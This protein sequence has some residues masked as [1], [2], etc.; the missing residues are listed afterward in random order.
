M[1]KLNLLTYIFISL[2]ILSCK[3]IDQ[4]TQ[5]LNEE[6]I[7]T[8][9]T[10]Y[11]NQSVDGTNVAR[12]VII[13]TP[14]IIDQSKDYPLVFAFHGRGG[15]NKIWVNK[16]KNF[17]DSGE[18]IGVYPQGYLDSWNLGTEP[19]KADDIEFISMIIN[20]LKQYNNIDM[21]K[22]YAIGISNGSGMVNKLGI[23]TSHFKAIAPIVS[24]LM[25]SMPILNNTKPI[26]VFQFNG[27]LDST[28]PINGGSRFGHVFLDALKSAEL[29]AT[30]FECSFPAEIQSNGNNTLY[31]FSDC[32]DGKEIRY[33]RIKNG[34]HNLEPSLP[35]MFLEI[36]NF[37]KKF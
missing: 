2:L 18:F 30:N 36:W 17:T 11:I 4:D 10:V 7:L 8:T 9:K 22:L 29:W 5:D 19:S 23:E 3:K 31:I 26:S 27:A 14:S 16:L 6:N 21:N 24:Q 12:S 35:T 1:N 34:Q 32:N 15:K 37:F 20:R 33:Y 28:I 25:E 13:Q